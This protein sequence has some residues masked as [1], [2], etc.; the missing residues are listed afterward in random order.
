VL[1]AAGSKRYHEVLQDAWPDVLQLSAASQPHVGCH[2]CEDGACRSVLPNVRAL[3]K[4]ACMHLVWT[5][6]SSSHALVKGSSSA[7]QL[8][9]TYTCTCTCWEGCRQRGIGQY[10]FFSWCPLKHFN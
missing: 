2:A 5:T 3:R 8:F 1:R 10:H 9:L 7:Q 6:Q 4:H